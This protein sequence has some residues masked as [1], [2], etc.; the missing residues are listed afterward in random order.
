MNLEARATL[1]N[2]YPPK[3]IAKILKALRVQ[4]QENDQLNA[5]EDIAGP[6]PE[7]PLKYGEILNEGGGF[8]DDVNGGYLP[9]GLVFAARRKEIEWVHSEGVHEVFPMQECLGSGQ[10]LL[11]LTFVDT[12]QSFDPFPRKM[13][14]R[15]CASEY[16]TK[17]QGNLQRALPASQLF[18]AMPHLESVKASVS[19]MISVEQS[20][21]GNPL[22]L[23]HHHISRAHFQGTAQRLIYVKLPAEDCQK[24]GEDKVG[25]IDQ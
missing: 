6:V 21:T 3:L 9:E 25:K 1:F 22:K 10:K 18:S 4:L 12:D 23:R 11:D 7:I 8:W 13:R 19:I 20:N 2:T 5:V 24:H 15:L 14:S 16:K 17:K